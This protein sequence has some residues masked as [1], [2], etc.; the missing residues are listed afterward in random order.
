MVMRQDDSCIL[1]MAMVRVLLD[2]EVP[3]IQPGV[4]IHMRILA[5]APGHQVVHCRRDIVL[6]PLLERHSNIIRRLEHHQRHGV[7]TPYAPIKRMVEAG[8]WVFGDFG[9]PLLRHLEIVGRSRSRRLHSK[10]I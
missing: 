8:G 4:C 7:P 9:D 10:V 1:P 2:Q 6:V 3:V 5:V